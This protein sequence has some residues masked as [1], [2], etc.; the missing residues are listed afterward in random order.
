MKKTTV[1]LTALTLVPAALT[2]A[3]AQTVAGRDYERIEA[4]RVSIANP[5]DDEPLNARIEDQVRRAIGL[6]PSKRFA[7]ETIDLALARARRDARIGDIDYKVEFGATGGVILD[8]SVTLREPA[9]LS[10]PRGMLATGNA[11]AFPVLYDSDGTFLKL[12]VE[13]T[14][15]HYGNANAWYGRPDLMLA[16]NPLVVGKPSGRGY[17]HWVEGFLHAGLYGITPITENLYAYGGISAIASGSMGQELFTDQTRGYLGIEDAYAGFVTGTTTTEGNRL[18]FN[19]SIGR[20]RFLLGDGFLIANTSANG[21]D[22]AALQANPR[23]AADMLALAQFSYNDTKIEAFHLDPDELPIV[24]SHTTIQGINF[25]T[26]LTQSLDVGLSFLR[27]PKSTFGY[28]TPT[29]T[30]SREGL[31]V[32]D[33]RFR[34]QPNPAGQSGPFVAGEFAL[35]RNENFPMRAYGFYGEVGYHFA[36][37]PWTPTFSYRYARFSGDDPN[38]DRFERWDPLLSGGNGEQWVQGINHFKIWQDSNVIAHRFQMRMRPTPKIEL[39]P[40]LWAFRA[41]STTN[42]GGNPALSFLGSDDLGYEVNLTGKLFVSR[43]VY[44]QGHVAATIPGEAVKSALGDDRDPW[45]STMLFVRT[46]F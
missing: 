2:A 14:A 45:W 5:S 44:V 10:E 40:Q 34:W 12:K 37:L 31:Q 6:F 13:S 30:F 22:R 27:V 20:Q 15:L 41:D 26:A 43:H 39:V 16:G 21:Y 23:W 33:A 9:E 18:A 35:Q 38:T 7:S 42:I 3:E 29:D 1:L 17:D 25:E 46:A 8:V 24:D 4:V 36:E 32:Y 28:Y 11:T 19:A